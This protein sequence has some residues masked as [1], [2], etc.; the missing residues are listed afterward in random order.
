M[1]NLQEATKEYWR[2]LNELETAYTKGEVTI[3]EVDAKVHL[4]IK[5]LGETRR[6]ALAYSWNSLRLWCSERLEIIAGV[7]MLGIITYAWAV[8]T[9]I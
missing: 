6:E 7:A 1:V 4:L 5:E 2:K 3:E 8:S 9:S